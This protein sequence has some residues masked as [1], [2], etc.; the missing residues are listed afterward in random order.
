MKTVHIYWRDGHFSLNGPQ[1]MKL[2]VSH[3]AWWIW[4]LQSWLERWL[5]YYL[6]K[7]ENEYWEKHDDEEA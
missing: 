4:L 3:L 1:G 7:V 2:R 6:V 5:Y